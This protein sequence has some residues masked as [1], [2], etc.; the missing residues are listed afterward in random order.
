MAFTSPLGVVDF[1]FLKASSLACNAPVQVLPT[2]FFF[3]LSPLHRLQLIPTRPVEH[4]VLP[5]GGFDFAAQWVSNSRIPTLPRN[6][7]WRRCF[8]V[9][10]KSP[11]S[12]SSRV[13]ERLEGSCHCQTAAVNCPCNVVDPTDNLALNSSTR[14]P[15]TVF[16]SVNRRVAPERQSSCWNPLLHAARGR[17]GLVHRAQPEPLRVAGATGCCPLVKPR[18]ATSDRVP[19]PLARKGLPRKTQSQQDH[20]LRHHLCPTA[21]APLAGNGLSRQRCVQDP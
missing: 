18:P 4:L 3:F 12:W 11:V 16:D 8:T 1:E 13:L 6:M 2:C 15:Q 21:A 5:I 19:D 20:L 14:L 7:G 17:R 10:W 9:S